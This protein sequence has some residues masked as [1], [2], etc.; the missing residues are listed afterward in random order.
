MWL[1][2][3]GHTLA[4]YPQ[5]VHGQAPCPEKSR[6]TRSLKRDTFNMSPHLLKWCKPQP[7]SFLPLKELNILTALFPPVNDLWQYF[8][9]HPNTQKSLQ[10]PLRWAGSSLSSLSNRT[11]MGQ[12]SQVCS[13]C[14]QHA[15]SLW[16]KVTGRESSWGNHHCDPS[17][18]LLLE[19]HV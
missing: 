12:T 9:A 4:A 17:L 13:S 16:W 10:A 2:W 3:E 19:Y 15:F 11:Y 1:P 5:P 18:S 14:A 6:R 7:P 8:G